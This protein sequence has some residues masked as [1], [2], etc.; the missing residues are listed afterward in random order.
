MR[1][2]QDFILSVF[3]YSTTGNEICTFKFYEVK[4]K[5]MNLWGGSHI[6]HIALISL[7]ILSS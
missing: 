1:G 4:K 3:E 6:E 2:I 5:K 7:G